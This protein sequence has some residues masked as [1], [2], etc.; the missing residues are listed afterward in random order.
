[1]LVYFSFRVGFSWEIV[2]MVTD[3]DLVNFAHAFVSS[4]ISGLSQFKL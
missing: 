1:M 2:N 4:L 3:F